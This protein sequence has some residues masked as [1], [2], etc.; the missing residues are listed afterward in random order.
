MQK[1]S[2]EK[3]QSF[4][5]SFLIWFCVFYV[6]IFGL[7]YF[8]GDRESSPQNPENPTEIGVEIV[9]DSLVRGQLLQV[10][11]TNFLTEK[12]QL[13]PIC[14]GKNFSVFRRVNQ[15][16]LKLDLAPT[17][18]EKCQNYPDQLL[19]IPPNQKVIWDVRAINA[20]TFSETGQ[21]FLQLRF[22]AAESQ[23]VAN[24][25]TFSVA[26]PGVF[27][28]LFRTIV[29]QPLFNLL[30]FLAEIIPGHSLGWAIVALTIL[31]RIFLFLPNQKAM[32]S[33]RALQKLQPKIEALKKKH[34]KN[35][36]MLALKTMEM[37]RTHKINP[38]SSCLPL[39]AQMPFLIGIY[40]IVRDGMSPHLGYFLYDFQQNFNFLSVDNYFFI[41]D[42]RLPE[43]FLLPVLVGGAQFLA[44]KL[45]LI[46]AKKQETKSKNNSKKPP[47][48]ADQ[49]Q[50][51]QKMMLY[52]LPVMIAVFT[53][54]FPSGIGIYWLTSTIFGIGQQK[55]VNYQLDRHP[56]V[57]RKC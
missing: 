54:T 34:G 26:E 22:D 3:V 12:I 39:L 24:S 14:S 17:L 5:K 4:L 46:S 43:L 18:D 57:H 30:V 56:E 23:I 25:N 42:L 52:V 16:D 10:Q 11:I 37:Y 27:R 47:E 21:Y 55:L 1:P 51:I 33:Q 40:F 36:Q 48:L 44:I 19:E 29:T 31:V 45:S 6:V 35:Q 41:W 38:M 13:P 9:D 28:Q 32:K 7:E 53:A 50:Q 49:M 2:L 20:E 8:L 15:Q